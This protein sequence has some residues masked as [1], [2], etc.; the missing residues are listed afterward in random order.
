[1]GDHGDFEGRSLAV[2]VVSIVLLVCASVF[3]FF[4]IISRGAIVKRIAVDDWLMVLAWGLSFGMTFVVCYATSYGFGRHEQDV[5]SDWQTTLHEATYAFSVLYN[6]ALMAEKTSILAFYLTLSK[7]RITFRWATIATMVVVNAGGL[8]LTLLNVFQCRPVSAVF[9]QQIPPS[10]HCTDIVTIYLSSAPLNIITDLAILFLPL[11]I[12]TGMR[13]PLKQKII[14]IVTFSFG[15]FAAAVD[16]VRIAALQ[17]AAETKLSEIQN[18]AQNAGSD[19]SPLQQLD[20]S[21]YASLSFMWSAV[22]VNVG[23]MC[24]CVPALKPLVSRFMPHMLRDVDDVTERAN[25][26]S[27]ARPTLEM[28]EAHRIPSVADDVHHQHTPPGGRNEEPMGMMDFLTTPDMTSLPTEGRHRTHT[29]TSN[30][31]RHTK[32]STPTFFDFV[33]VNGKKSMVHMTNRESYFP[34]IMVTVLF[35]I[36]GF[37]YGLLDVLN[38]QFQ[39]AAH[40]SIGQTTGIHSAYYIGYLFG[41]WL[42][43]RWVLR[44]WGFKACFSVG[45]SVYACGTLIF[46]PAA[47]LTSF[48]AYLITNLFVGMGL[49]V[50][51]VSANPFIILC[52]PAQYAEIRLNLSQGVQAI[53]TVIAPLIADR[54]FVQ[55]SKNADSLVSTQYAYLGIALFTIILAVIYHY[56]PLPEATDEELEDTCERADRAN[57]ANLGQV[58]IATLVLAACAFSMFCYVGAQEVSGTGFNGFIAAVRP[59]LNASNY[60]AIAHTAFAVSRFSAAGL[61]MLVKPRTLLLGFFLGAVLF[62]ALAVTLTGG[63]ALAML[64]L[65]FFMEGPI[66][67]LLFSQA[68]RGQGRHT[69]L[70]SVIVTSMIGGGAAFSPI[71]NIL[72]TTAIGGQYPLVVAVAVFAAGTLTPIALMS[73]PQARTL[74]DPIRDCTAATEDRPSSTSTMTSRALTFL[75]ARKKGGSKDLGEVDFRER[76]SP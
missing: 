43:G 13:L 30:S 57:K 19:T 32:P 48:P 11:P 60:M 69:K 18:Q 4:R 62:Q 70:A 75:T 26:H 8:A 7:T 15:L 42:V 61:G 56:V 10:A 64:I 52:G 12:L 50:L 54:A 22:E 33:H 29:V 46:W 14:L 1:M 71:S 72:A 59:N 76:A 6:P 17:S 23:I 39:Q 65:S 21:W 36:W 58:P 44:H 66:F 45:L 73:V 35:F 55:R 5:P 38:Q 31:T 68:L 49:A 24:G 41:P 34:I 74:V 47:V 40:M 28:V 51:E 27:N 37:E 20:F 16:V 2:F 63:T 9:Q 67:A 25:S 53:G 3:V